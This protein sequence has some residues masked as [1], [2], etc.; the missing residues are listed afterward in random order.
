MRYLEL[1]LAHAV[2][3][4]AVDRAACVVVVCVDRDGRRGA[5]HTYVRASIILLLSAM[6]TSGAGV[7]ALKAHLSRT[8]Y[9]K[10]LTSLEDIKKFLMQ[11]YPTLEVKEVE[12]SDDEG[13]GNWVIVCTP[14]YSCVEG[15]P[16]NPARMVFSSDGTYCLEVMMKSVNSGSWKDSLPPHRTICD[17]LSTLL[18]NSGYVLCPGIRDFT[19]E[20]S[21]TVY[22]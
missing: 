11:C 13:T 5:R 17:L 4:Y 10:C 8:T 2:Q 16:I 6:A 9:A 18:A 14:Y 15:R 22:V 21:E 1:S 7:W 12:V 19:G 3:R 20:F